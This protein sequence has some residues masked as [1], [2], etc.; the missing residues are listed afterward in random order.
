MQLGAETRCERRN[1]F[2]SSALN[3]SEGMNALWSR[4]QLELTI[5]LQD[6]KADAWND[7]EFAQFLAIIDI[8][9]Q[10]PTVA[11]RSDCSLYRRVDVY[12][13]KLISLNAR[14]LIL[15]SSLRVCG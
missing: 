10:I 4:M 13:S 3:R 15:I 11:K 5:H 12:A 6:A 8:S 1:D 2:E 7:E 14:L 9:Q